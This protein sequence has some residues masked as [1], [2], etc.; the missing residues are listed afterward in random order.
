MSTVATMTPNVGNDCSLSIIVPSINGIEYLQR[1]VRALRG[2]LAST[3]EL[4]VPDATVGRAALELESFPGL[5]VRVVEN[6]VGVGLP[7]LRSLGLSLAKGAV[8]AMTEDHCVPEHDWCAELRRLHCVFP[9]QVI[10]GPIENGAKQTLVDWACYFCEYGDFMLPLV[11]AP[12]GAVPGTNASYKRSLVEANGS[13][14]AAGLWD[15]FLHQQL[16]QRG[17]TF[18][19][20]PRLRVLNVKSF[21]R[22]QFD[23]QSFAFARSF[24]QV[25]LRGASAIQV[26]KWR[27]LSPAL[28]FLK[29][30]RHAR[31]ILTKKR[32]HLRE[33]VGSLG[34][35]FWF[36]C[37]WSAGEMVGY[38]S[39]R[40]HA[41]P[42]EPKT[43]TLRT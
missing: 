19:M 35:V 9:E 41:D 27:L 21:T 16:A 1:C 13:L 2:Q 20:E 39:H 31:K 15:Y 8:I 3:D 28:P 29:T 18:R 23:E 7:E 32:R 26:W 40:R 6:P 12:A 33:F 4:I 14:F 5:I 38:W 11:E 17:A 22:A 30:A 25:R 34:W 42:A 43:E 36:Q 10:G 24:A 37:V